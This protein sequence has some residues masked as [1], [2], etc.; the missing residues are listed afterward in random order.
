[1]SK[2]VTLL[3]PDGVKRRLVGEIISRFEKK[4]FSLQTIRS[5]S[6]GL[7]SSENE[8]LRKKL[9]EHYGEEHSEKAYYSKLIDFMLSGTLIVIVWKGNLSVANQLVGITDPCGSPSGTIRGDFS[10]DLPENLIHVSH[11]EIDAKRELKIW[12]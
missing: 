8:R 12:S 9:E 4:G 2:F 5:E 10:C 1:M 3:K 11:T 7:D 6:P